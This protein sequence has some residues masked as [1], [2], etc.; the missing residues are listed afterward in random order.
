MYL[1]VL[2]HKALLEIPC[3]A[4][5]AFRAIAIRMTGEPVSFPEYGHKLTFW[6]KLF[7][8]KQRR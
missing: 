8:E 1:S 3:E 5:A 4:T 7:G 6:Q 2:K